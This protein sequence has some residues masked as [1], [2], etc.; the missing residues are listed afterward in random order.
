MKWESTEQ[1]T[2]SVFSLRNSATRSE[3]AINSVGHT[4]VLQKHFQSYLMT[5]LNVSSLLQLFIDLIETIS[6]DKRNMEN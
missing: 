4:N 3:N 1:A 6:L 5:L 2:T